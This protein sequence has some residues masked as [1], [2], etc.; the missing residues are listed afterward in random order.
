MVFRKY[1]PD[2]Q[3]GKV[4]TRIFKAILEA[5]NK[6][7]MPSFRVPDAVKALGVEIHDPR[8]PDFPTPRVLPNPAI[9]HPAFKT[10]TTQVVLLHFSV[11][12]RI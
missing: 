10:V 11:F 9:D 3:W 5:R 4:D 8:S 7:K 2:K 1:R 12:S 6:R